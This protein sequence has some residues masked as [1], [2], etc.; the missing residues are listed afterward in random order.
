MK[1]EGLRGLNFL[2]VSL[3]VSLVIITVVWILEDGR[4]EAWII[5]IGEIAIPLTIWLKSQ[6][7]K[8]DVAVV[9][10]DLGLYLHWLCRHLGEKHRIRD[11]IP[12]NVCRTADD[13]E[14][15][16]LNSILNRQGSFLITGVAGVGKSA[17]LQWL[18]FQAAKLNLDSGELHQSPILLRLQDW[19]KGQTLKS[20]L[21][22][23]WI[24][25]SDPPETIRQY[26]CVLFLDG[27]DEI[28]SGDNRKFRQLRRFLNKLPSSVKIVASSREPSCNW[29]N[30]DFEVVEVKSDLT[31]EQIRRFA[32]CYLEEVDAEAFLFLLAVD[33]YSFSS[34]DRSRLADRYTSGKDIEFLMRTVGEGESHDQSYYPNLFEPFTKNAFQLTQLIQYYQHCIRHGSLPLNLGSVTEHILRAMWQREQHRCAKSWI[35]F[36]EVSIILA[37]YAYDQLSYYPYA[38]GFSTIGILNAI[39]HGKRQYRF[40]RGNKFSKSLKIASNLLFLPI[41]I[42]VGFTRALMTALWRRFYSFTVKNGFS[43]LESSL[44]KLMK[45]QRRLEKT[46]RHHRVAKLYQPLL[47]ILIG[48]SIL[49]IVVDSEQDSDKETLLSFSDTRFQEYFVAKAF[50]E[51]NYPLFAPRRYSTGW[52][53]VH[54]RWDRIFIALSGLGQD[55]T[56]F[57]SEL[58]GIQRDAN[59]R[60]HYDATH[61]SD[62]YLATKCILTLQPNS[63]EDSFLYALTTSIV[64]IMLD[65]KSAGEKRTVD[66]AKALYFLGNGLDPLDMV[67]AI[68]ALSPYQH[69]QEQIQHIV[70]LF[71]KNERFREAVVTSLISQLKEQSTTINNSDTGKFI[72]IALGEIGD[73]RAVPALK[74]TLS[75]LRSNHHNLFSPILVAL[76]Q[77]GDVEARENFLEY[78]AAS[79]QA[80]NLK[81][82]WKYIKYLDMA[83]I[84][85]LVKLLYR[86]ARLCMYFAWSVP[87]LGQRASETLKKELEQTQAV[88][89]SSQDTAS[90]P[91]IQAT[92]IET[93]GEIGGDCVSEA[94]ATFLKIENSNFITC[95]AS[96]IAVAKNPTKFKAEVLFPLLLSNEPTIRS[97]TA[98]ALGRIGDE[99]AIRP[100]SRLLED[101]SLVHRQ[102]EFGT[103]ESVSEFA[104]D[105]LRHINT[106]MS[107]AIAFNWY[108]RR[109]ADNFQQH[110]REVAHAKLGMLKL[111][112]GEAHEVLAAWEHE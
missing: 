107:R 80:A 102:S 30:I 20:F 91:V 49:Q 105:A 82:R 70:V 98:G 40:R 73:P 41:A 47:N 17:L 83:I 27:L 14:I 42:M 71:A 56:T 94:I 29:L 5:L 35:S 112:T 45:R 18:A 103:A 75:A 87:Q 100:L 24:D 51:N 64:T 97:L 10:N 86:D 89:N 104:A 38:P 67:T 68:E 34:K 66:Y 32:H 59:N 16:A 22:Q 81:E 99:Q 78:L 88:T 65:I 92:L 76:V 57:I 52:Q 108:K 26:N 25:A 110:S 19:A 101:D 50:L 93:L 53:R 79:E 11:F 84:P 54:S 23:Q 43:F 12:P 7:V 6:L 39:Y 3:W 9:E 46:I 106:S 28:D 1:K 36:D 72:I 85:E 63:L 90:L 109:L 111:G 61:S 95:Q 2:Q 74:Q 55:K 62:L 96:L 15:Q 33:T 60:F 77:L 58:A 21:K 8:T 31:N 4:F 69:Y 44:Y 37:E 13:S 48:T